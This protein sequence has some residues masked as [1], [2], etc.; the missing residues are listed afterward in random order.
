M[1]GTTK[2][3]FAKNSARPLQAL[4]VSNLFLKPAPLEI[5]STDQL[6][7]LL[8]SPKKELYQ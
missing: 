1:L 4:P 8:C 6:E 2:T 5:T 7:D 3:E